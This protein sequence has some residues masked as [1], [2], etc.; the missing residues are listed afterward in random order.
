MEM[1]TARSS[2]CQRKT[3]LRLWIGRLQL[4]GYLR[5]VFASERLGTWVNFMEHA[6][7]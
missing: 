2:I 7:M 1:D 5:M 3:L 6:V 4:S